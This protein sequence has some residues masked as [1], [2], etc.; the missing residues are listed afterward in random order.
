MHQQTE[1]SMTRPF[2]LAALDQ[3][4]QA[5]DGAKQTGETITVLGGLVPRGAR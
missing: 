2:L 4:H 1:T 3:D 5:A